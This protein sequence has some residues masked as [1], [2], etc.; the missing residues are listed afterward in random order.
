MRHPL[1]VLWLSLLVGGAPALAGG[2]AGLAW[3]YVEANTGGS[4]GGHVALRVGET[5]YHIQQSADGLYELNR[6]EWETFRHTYA[7]LQNRTLAVAELDVSEADRERVEMRLAKAYVAQRAELEQRERRALDLAWLEAWRSGRAPP[8]LAGAGLLA[9][10][11]VDPDAEALRAH[12]AAELGERFLDDEL[13]RVEVRLADYAPERGELEGLRETLLL[14]T[15]LVAL[16]D[17]SRVSEQ[18]LLPL[19]GDL[20]EPLSPAERRGAERFAE[21]QRDAVIQLLRSR[22]PDRGRALL[23]ALARYQAL[24]RSGTSGRLVLLDAYAGADA[25]PPESERP[26][27][28]TLAKLAA[29]LGPLL[30]SGRTKVLTRRDFDEMQYNLLE[31]GAGIW[32][33]YE[34]GAR[35][36]P[37]RK[38]PR[39]ALPAA[40]R[41]LEFAP[42]QADAAQLAA[43]HLGGQ[44]LTGIR[45]QANARRLAGMQTPGVGR[46][47]TRV[48]RRFT[49]VAK[50]HENRATRRRLAHAR[51]AAADLD[52]AADD[53]GVE[54]RADRRMQQLGARLFD[55]RALL[56]D[57][58]LAAFNAA[59]G[60]FHAALRGAILELALF[61]LIAWQQALLEERLCALEVLP[62]HLQTVLVQ[63]EPCGRVLQLR[64][65]QIRFGLIERRL[66]QLGIESHELLAGRNAVAFPH[67]HRLHDPGRLRAKIDRDGRFDLPRDQQQ[68]FHLR[69]F[70]LKRLL[71][72]GRRRGPGPQPQKRAIPDATQNDQRYQ[73]LQQSSHVA[74]SDE[75]HR[76]TVRGKPLLRFTNQIV[77]RGLHHGGHGGP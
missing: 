6:D 40:A 73:P 29:E 44:L 68:V 14:H 36:E 49:R 53:E 21:A 48:E 32:R 55:G 11:L 20:A 60:A 41:T 66:C 28:A 75:G 63:V 37:V 7:G 65:L 16:D 15:A 17:A 31:V 43:E 69:D 18:A 70:R 3:T 8:P 33:E 58:R 39:H 46:R 26:Q 22:R 57:P 2:D 4:S 10:G 76:G 45:I 9:P 5:T 47:R 64:L 23:L 67:G 1:H 62:S 56:R 52:G 19:S 72:E 34:R 77:N 38:L 71:A 35:G 24:A 12:V 74:P 54:R 50:R 27:A 42:A 59:P 25:F 30:R 13:G 61:K 51:H